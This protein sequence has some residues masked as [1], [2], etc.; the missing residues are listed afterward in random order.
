MVVN[1][2]DNSLSPSNQRSIEVERDQIIEQ[3]QRAPGI[4]ELMQVYESVEAAYARAVPQ[5]GIRV[6]SSTNPG[7]RVRDAHLG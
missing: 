2:T 3:A 7:I 5:S 4:A 6:A 1:M